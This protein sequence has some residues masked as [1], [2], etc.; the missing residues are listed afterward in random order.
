[1]LIVDDGEINRQIL[2]IQSERWGMIPTVF[3]TPKE[4]LS[5]LEG[6]PPVDLAVLDWQMPEIDGYDLARRIHQRET[7][8]KLPLVLPEFIYPHEGI[9][10][11]RSGR[12]RRAADEA[13]Q[14]SQF[15]QCVDSSPRHRQVERAGLSPAG[16]SPTGRWPS[17][18]SPCNILR[19]RRQRDQ[20]ARQQTRLIA[21][22]LRQ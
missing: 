16:G 6:N 19:R 9:W 3:E 1:M 20:P 2:K 13:G 11:P 10:Q 12:I 4:A 22:R 21:I 7:Y 8:N 5:W 18:A 14:T 17:V 15:V